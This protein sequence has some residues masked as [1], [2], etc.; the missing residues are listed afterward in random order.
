MPLRGRLG[1]SV[2]VGG[3]AWLFGV[4]PGWFWVL[5]ALPVAL[6]LEM[7]CGFYFPAQFIFQ[8]GNSAGPWRGIPA[9]IF[10]L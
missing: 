7:I 6:G 1:S 9:F 8:P 3:S 4:V 5:S 10:P 2:R